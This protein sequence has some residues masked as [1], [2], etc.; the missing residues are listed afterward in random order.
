MKKVNFF[1][2]LAAAALMTGGSSCSNDDNVGDGGPEGQGKSA[3]LTISI[4]N[5][6]TRATGPG[7]AAGSDN[8]VS[9]FSMFVIDGNGNVGWKQHVTNP[10]TIPTM[11]VTTDAKEVYVIANAGDKTS[12]YTTKAGL[13]AAT[14]AL[15]SQTGGRWATGDVVIAASDWTTSGGVTTVNKALTLNFIAAR[16]QVTVNNQMTGYDGSNGTVLDNVAVLNA[17]STSLLFGASLV[18]SS[19]EV[20]QSGVV[21]SGVANWPSSVTVATNSLVDNYNNA[22]TFPGTQD[23]CYYVY[24]NEATTAA[25]F[26]TIVT[27]IGTDADG[28]AVYFPVHLAAHENFTQGSM[29]TGVVRGK[30]YNIGIILKGDATTGNGGGG[31]DPTLPVTSASLDVTISINDWIPVALEKEFN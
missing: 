3:S 9:N 2:M 26:P 31:T 28:N 23:F 20:L 13:L 24:E 4:Q 17:N 29:T 22:A 6:G 18:P 15:D 11:T 30:S 21:L 25:Q 7:A 16:I 19:G 10:S 27:V 8:V 14:E 5:P 12:A 1:A